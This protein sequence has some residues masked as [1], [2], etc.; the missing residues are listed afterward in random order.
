MKKSIY[1]LILP[2]LFLLFAESSLQ[3]QSSRFRFEH[4][5]LDQGL[6]QST[7]MCFIQDKR[8]FIW[9]GTQEGLC[10]YDG[11]TFVVYKH[12]QNDPHSISS[13]LIR[14]LYEDKAGIIWVG[15]F[16]G[17]INA[18]D[19]ATGKFTS[20]RHDPS[21]PR[22]LS[23]NRVEALV[24][25]RQG[26]LWV[27]TLG[28][29]NRFD[30]KTGHFTRYQHQ[31]ADPAS[32]SEN[33]VLS[34]CQDNAGIIWVGTYGGGLNAFD[35]T[36]GKF[37][38]FVNE[39]GKSTSVSHNIIR[40]V[41]Y[42]QSHRLWV[43]TDAGLN[44]FNPHKQDFSSYTHDPANPNSLIFNVVSSIGEDRTGSLWVGTKGGGLHRFE[45]QHG[46]S[47]RFI[48][49]PLQP[50]SLSADQVWAI[51]EDR[52]GVLWIGTDGGGINLLD[53][54]KNQFAHFTHDSTDP[55]SLS[56]PIVWSFCED[57]SETLWVG[58]MKGLNAFNA[59][60]G[61]FT[62]Y[63]H[64]PSNPRSLSFDNVSTIAEDHL[65]N[66]WVGTDGGGL[67]RFDRQTKQFTRFSP[68]AA[69]ATSL[70][71]NGVNLIIEDKSHK[72]WIGFSDKGID[73][74]DQAKN[75]FTHYVHDPSNPNSLSGNH[76]MALYEGRDGTIWI[77]TLGSGL[78]AFN[79][80]TG[81]FT[82]Y[83]HD[84]RNPSSLN[85][86]RVIS[87]YEDPTGALWVGTAGGGLN[88]L[89]RSTGK[90]THFTE[91][92]GL[93][94]N[95]VYGILPDNEGQLWLS[96]NQGIC[97]FSPKNK[98]FR[99]F[100]VRD[101]LQNNE[102][103][104]WAYYRTQRGK[105]L[106]GGI[107]GFNAFYPEQIK[108]NPTI[109]AISF[110]DFK[111]R[112]KSVVPDS[113]HSPLSKL[114]TDT[115]EITLPYY[116]N[117][118]SL[119]FAALDYTAPAKHQYA[120]MLEGLD[121][122]WI[123]SGTQHSATYT[124]LD[125]GHYVFRVKGS[126]NNGLWN[127]Q[128][129]SLTIVIHP[130]WWKTWWA[131]TFYAFAVVA[132]ALTIIRF[133]LNKIALK[134]QLK[135]EQVQAEKFQ[136]IERIKTHFFTNISHEFRTPLTLILGPITKLIDENT[137]PQIKQPLEMMQRN[138]KRLLLLINQLLDISK[139]ET[140]K[141]RLNGSRAD[142]V[143]F[144]EPIVDSFRLLTV[145][146][147]L[148]IQLHAEP[149]EIVMDFDGDKLEKVLYNLLSNAYKFTPAQ[150]EIRITISKVLNDGKEWMELR[151]RDT[152]IGMPPAKLP[153]IFDRYYQVDDAKTRDQA[154]QGTGIGLSLVKDL[155]ELHGGSIRATS[156]P[157]QGSEFIVCLPITNNRIFEHNEAET[158]EEVPSIPPI[159]LLPDV[160]NEE[161]V[162]SPQT[163]K[164]KPV[165]LLVEDNPDMRA[166]IVSYLSDYAVVEACDGIEG[167]EKATEHIPDLILCDVM[168]PRM[169]GY[170]VCKHLRADEKTS[171]IP[172]IMLTAKSSRESRIEGLET[173]ANDYLNKP[174][175]AQELLLKVANAI[176]NRQNLIQH[177]Q[178]LLHPN[179]KSAH[180]LSTEEVFL[181]K[182]IRIIEDNLGNEAFSVEDL[183]K[184]AGMS[185]T[186]VHRKLIALTNQSASDLIRT[187]RLEKALEMLKNNTDTI[188]YIAYAVGFSSPNYFARC[189]HQQY[190][191]SPSDFKKQL[192]NEN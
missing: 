128:G 29:L 180:I 74:Y 55:N 172:I 49:D 188:S 22:S 1:S 146:K 46:R 106:F 54:K 166:F 169:D 109:P 2:V 41:F 13:N 174:F 158:D 10:R 135:I 183:G 86:N 6:P 148:S 186:Q 105:L 127:E 70:A 162:I 181:Q 11:Y 73:R 91:K 31:P 3:A 100:D 145:K 133:Q 98:T 28:G 144:I 119:D 120:Y 33:R 185:R 56:H 88:L 175:D 141:M 123:Y 40:C 139:L 87:L 45:P 155:V 81:R 163:E 64:N 113:A 99:N 32:L 50:N 160:A 78:N 150:G 16:S 58:T 15:T 134:N 103:N 154:E 153:Y 131:Y 9:V 68:N 84:P 157:G 35:P 69:Q 126:N 66:L 156:Q 17:G 165:I 82:R 140:S 63:V 4:L 161:I 71:S 143:A 47:T 24:E 176:R 173:G 151:V 184:Q 80:T 118:L 110:T 83:V 36:T 52:G 65:G 23:H 67:N 18:F 116:E 122:D 147:P 108:D 92:E 37:K 76:V 53:R 178:K 89:A 95:V 137:N 43:G 104:N 61:Q 132:I 20:Y 27:G 129:S 44:L 34:L 125:P 48:H 177:F 121:K 112:N 59:A 114:I 72:L 171:H 79:P 136:E 7:P 164:G 77:G 94:N 39:P 96:T 90:F 75:E 168:M 12:D 30:R 62:R 159:T 102:F 192:L 189:F 111:L 97:Q 51:F 8:G 25:D 191:Y 85:E 142:V 130:P 26:N 149:Q 152:G 42:D 107:N 170:T 182:I 190:G 101:G 167:L 60:T 115:R 38:H 21:N 19:P 187:V 57:K 179:P 117:M 5:S 14:A 93:P 138:A 124:N